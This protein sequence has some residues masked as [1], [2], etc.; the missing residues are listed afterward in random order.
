M[1]QFR[2]K[3]HSLVLSINFSVF[4]ATNLLLLPTFLLFL[5]PI[6]MCTRVYV[7]HLSSRATERDVESFCKGM[8]KVS[9]IISTPLNFNTSPIILFSSQTI[10]HLQIRDVVLK[11]GF[12]FVEFEDSRDAEVWI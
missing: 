2:L 5:R 12:G 4:S 3:N 10:F 8:G 1:C 9:S 6:K 11:N 7:G